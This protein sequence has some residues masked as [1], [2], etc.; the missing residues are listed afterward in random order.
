M[1]AEGQSSLSDAVLQ[2][3][4][5]LPKS[6]RT[7]ALDPA[8]AARI[9][10]RHAARRAA[11]LAGGL[12]LPPGPLGWLTVLPELLGVWRIQAQLVADIA[13]LHG[14]SAELNREQMLYCLFRHTA[15]Q[16]L[17]DLAVRSGE[18]ATAAL[19]QK[20]AQAIGV[21]LSQRGLSAGLARWV[22]MLGAASVAAYAYWDTEQVGRS[23]L[24]LF[25]A[26]EPDASP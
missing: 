21:Q 7:R 4:A 1:N 11:A 19:L 2:L 26:Q 14:H 3:V 25:A 12:A 23:A 15:A 22:P 10:T 8:Q 9:A 17:R 13:A 24:A 5:V 18:R 6:D 16:A 20:A